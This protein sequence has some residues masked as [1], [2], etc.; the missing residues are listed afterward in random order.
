MRICRPAVGLLFV[1]AAVVGGCG[2]ASQSPA[3]PTP[4]PS[5]PVVAAPQSPAYDVSGTWTGTETHAGGSGTL[6]WNLQQSGNSISG[7]GGVTEDKERD[8]PVAATLSGTTLT[9]T[10]NYGDSCV[11]TVSGTAIV[12]VDNTMAGTFSG[13]DCQGTPVSNGRLSLSLPRPNLAGEW[14]GAAPTT[15]FGSG[16]WT[17]QLRQ[18]GSNITGSVTFH[19]ANLQETDPFTGSQT[20][21]YGGPVLSFS[22][23][24]TRCPGVSVSGSSDVSLTS[25]HIGGTLTLSSGCLSPGTNGTFVFD[26]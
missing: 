11:R 1:A 13:H 26:R 12:A 16:S 10:F 7:S 20:Y 17:W 3:A 9:F 4:A 19:T 2:G 24:L 8:G 21:T 23:P 5:T 25:T 14:S 22:F 15:A 18:D 6:F